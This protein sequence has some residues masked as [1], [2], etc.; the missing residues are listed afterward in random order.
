MA[1]AWNSL[2]MPHNAR[3]I[4]VL[5][6]AGLVG[7]ACGAGPPQ[8]AGTSHPS[9][10]A[11]AVA[12]GDLSNPCSLLVQSDVETVARHAM[13][14]TALKPS[15]VDQRCGYQNPSVPHSPQD[16]NGIFSVDLFLPLRRG[17]TEQDFEAAIS[18]AMGAAGYS[19]S[20]DK[21][22]SSLGVPARAIVDPSSDQGVLVMRTRMD[23]LSI[24][25]Q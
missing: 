8:A 19:P 1:P 3:S 18:G 17:A 11:S 2:L 12:K 22:I 14:V 15:E 23:V 9:P 6:M 4:A 7:A 16:V 24:M 20:H 13:T 5:T 25:G 21:T 10:S